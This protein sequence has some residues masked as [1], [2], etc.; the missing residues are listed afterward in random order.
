MK[1]NAEGCE[2]DNLVGDGDA[3]WTE[4]LLGINS[5][6]PIM[7]MSSELSFFLTRGIFFDILLMDDVQTEFLEKESE[8]GSLLLLKTSKTFCFATESFCT[9][10]LIFSSLLEILGLDEELDCINLSLFLGRRKLR[11]N[12]ELFD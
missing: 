10:S 9:I 8:V 1:T 3:G 11:I 2:V 7:T 5:L 4:E 12:Q 6:S